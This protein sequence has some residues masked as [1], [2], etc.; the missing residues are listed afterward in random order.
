M[1]LPHHPHASDAPL[2]HHTW[3]D[4][5]IFGILSTLNDDTSKLPLY[6]LSPSRSP[7]LLAAS[8]Q[9]SLRQTS[10]S[11]SRGYQRKPQ[12][13]DPSADGLAA[14]LGGSSP[15]AMRA[16]PRAMSSSSFAPH[17]THASPGVPLTR[18]ASLG[19]G[20]LDIVAIA[21]MRGAAAHRSLASKRS[22][23]PGS[24]GGVGASASAPRAPG[25]SNVQSPA[26]G[27][28]H[29]VGEDVLDSIPSPY[30][31]W[32]TM[33]AHPRLP[34]GQGPSPAAMQQPWA[35]R[36]PP[37][38]SLAAGVPVLAALAD[39]AAGDLWGILFDDS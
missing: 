19:I 18:T 37:A 36:S 33:A 34:Q 8:S 31:S 7:T 38:G 12:I 4:E 32:K 14:S 30:L 5:D 1:P 21:R 35:L 39:D 22:T 6:P 10:L 17:E 11:S 23:T 15:R 16:A 9:H 28:A 3:V 26:S 13:H 25:S 24:V 20:A 2:L 27:H 29:P